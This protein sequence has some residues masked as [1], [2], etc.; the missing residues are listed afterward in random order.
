MPQGVTGCN[1]QHRGERVIS[2]AHCKSTLSLFSQTLGSSVPSIWCPQLIALVPSQRLLTA[3]SPRHYRVHGPENDILRSVRRSIGA[4]PD[5]VKSCTQ[6]EF[7]E[8]S[9]KAPGLS[10]TEGSRD[11]QSLFENQWRNENWHNYN[12]T[13]PPPRETVPWWDKSNNLWLATLAGVTLK[14]SRVLPAKGRWVLRSAWS[15]KPLHVLIGKREN[16]RR[17]PRLSELQGQCVKW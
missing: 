5:S 13:C 8:E 7:I 15:P 11:Q 1:L 16:H 4:Q 10:R 12:C 2:A 6:H 9:K 14:P 17:G 3:T